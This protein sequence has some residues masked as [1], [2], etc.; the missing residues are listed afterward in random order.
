[1]TYIPPS[2]VD[3]QDRSIAIR[4]KRK[5]KRRTQFAIGGLVTVLAMGAT[6]VVLTKATAEV[7]GCAALDSG[8]KESGTPVTLVVELVGNTDRDA[9]AAAEFVSS[10]LQTSASD[11]ETAYDV[12]IVLL[13]YGEEAPI[14]GCLAATRRIVSPET[15]LETYQD[16]STSADTKDHLGNVLKDKRTEQIGWIV[17]EVNAQVRGVDFDGRDAGAPQLSP[18]LAWNA[19]MSHDG[20]DT[21][22]AVMSPMISTVDDCFSTEKADTGD[23]NDTDPA[24][25]KARVEDCK[26]FGE[27]DNVGAARTSIVAYTADLDANQRRTALDTVEQLC[28]VATTDDCSGNP[29]E[30]KDDTSS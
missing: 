14:D 30:P 13:T 21:I 4:T 27:I 11:I 12:E 10:Q 16:T 28:A 24:D 17:D 2:P 26:E 18:R 20:P 19:A 23:V 1:M 5:K 22:L 9:T 7:T 3:I 8:S 15:D 25:A 29:T 6:A